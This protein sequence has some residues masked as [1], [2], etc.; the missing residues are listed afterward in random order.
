MLVDYARIVCWFQFPYKT[1]NSKY[2]NYYRII[3]NDCTKITLKK[4]ITSKGAGEGG[5]EE[6]RTNYLSGAGRTMGE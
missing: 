3:K 2:V 1:N 6:E 5:G 4:K